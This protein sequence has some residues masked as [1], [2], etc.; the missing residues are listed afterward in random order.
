MAPSVV[1]PCLSSSSDHHWLHRCLGTGMRVGAQNKFCHYRAS[2]VQLASAI[3][4]LSLLVCWWEQHH[5]TVTSGTYYSDLRNCDSSCSVCVGK[6]VTVSRYCRFCA[7]LGD[8]R[9][10]PSNCWLP[11][12]LMLGFGGIR[13]WLVGFVLGCQSL[14]ILLG[15]FS[16]I[17]LR[18]LMP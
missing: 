9:S 2:L 7:R 12:P 11:V 17:N 1:Y 13:M 16:V 18:L 8:G 5:D 3:V 6:H 4:F 14:V 10:T 15:L